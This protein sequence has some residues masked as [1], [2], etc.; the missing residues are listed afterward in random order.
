VEILLDTACTVYFCIFLSRL[1]N[2][3]TKYCQ[4]S[5]II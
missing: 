5:F 4:H 3:C 1:I 2:M